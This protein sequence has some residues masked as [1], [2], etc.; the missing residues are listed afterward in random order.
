MAIEEL[1]S[2]FA[3]M[4]DYFQG[5]T[6][7]NAPII[8]NI[9]SGGNTEN[10]LHGNEVEP[11]EEPKQTEPD[12]EEMIGK[13]LTE[14]T[15]EHKTL[16]IK[17][18]WAGVYWYLRWAYNFPVDVQEFCNKI[19]TLPYADNLEISCNYDNIRRFANMSFIEQDPRQM[20][21]VKPSKMDSQAFYQC[22]E[23]ALVLDKKL[24][25]NRKI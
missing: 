20:E 4:K 14:I 8:I 9:N 17:Q 12:T 18:K 11:K 10:N 22:R 19:Q 16:N 15:G 25:E 24:G 21:K 13:A 1:E 23:V 5:T 2:L 6:T 3:K 7:I